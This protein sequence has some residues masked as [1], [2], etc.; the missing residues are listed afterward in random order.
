MI[1]P[2]CLLHAGLIH[3]S[4]SYWTIYH[5]FKIILEWELFIDS[6]QIQHSMQKCWIQIQ[7]SMQNHFF[8]KHSIRY[9]L[10][11]KKHLIVELKL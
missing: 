11:F 1:I 3:I 5:L 2:V 10:Y 7:H 9:E 4:P 6:I 8:K